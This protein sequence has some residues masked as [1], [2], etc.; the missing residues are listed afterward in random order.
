MHQASTEDYDIRSYI[1][2][3]DEISEAF[4]DLEVMVRNIKKKDAEM[5]EARINEAEL[6]NEQQ[7]MEFKMLAS[8]INPH[9]LYNT[10]ETIRMKAF[11][12]NDKEVARAIK[13]LGKSMRYVL[14]NTGTSYTTLSRELEHVN[15]YL[16]IQKLRF[17][18]KFD[19]I[20]EIGEDVDPEKIYILPLLL[21]PVVEN[22]ILHGLEERSMEA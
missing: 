17:T 22:A 20:T 8:Q 11:A 15:V 19:G 2:G 9:F 21:Q 3:Q 13:L 16:D 1:Q 14:E 5:Y 4:S 12:A 10:L 7:V 6:L 18:D